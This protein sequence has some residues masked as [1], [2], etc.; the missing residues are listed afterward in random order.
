MTTIVVVMIMM[1]II[2]ISIVITAPCTN[3]NNVSH[4]DNISR[5]N[6]VVDDGD[7]DNKDTN[8]M[9]PPTVTTSAVKRSNDKRGPCMKG[10]CQPISTPPSSNKQNRVIHLKIA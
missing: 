5:D 3:S 2:I 4:G 7:G 9:P 1:K 6:D 8:I 10:S